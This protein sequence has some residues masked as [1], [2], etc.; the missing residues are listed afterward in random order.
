[1][2][3]RELVEDIRLRIHYA[4]QIV[5]NDTRA[6]PPVDWEKVLADQTAD[7]EYQRQFEDGS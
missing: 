7:E 6:L 3:T 2:T 1:M 5:G 4:P